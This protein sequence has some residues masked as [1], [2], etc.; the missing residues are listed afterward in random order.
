MD[1]PVSCILIRLPKQLSQCVHA[2]PCMRCALQF[3]RDIQKKEELRKVQKQHDNGL[4]ASIMHCS[5]TQLRKRVC[6]MRMHAASGTSMK[7]PISAWCI[8]GNYNVV[9][10]CTLP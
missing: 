3:C 4:L 10:D 2:S 7:N 1:G 6:R 9:A 5:M 8:D